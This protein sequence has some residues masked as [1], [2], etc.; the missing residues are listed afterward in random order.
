[1]SICAIWGVPRAGK[2][3]LAV[4]LAY[5]VS[6]GD[7]SICL[8]SPVEYSELSAVLGKKI[9]E[10]HSLRAAL[11]GHAGIRQTVFKVDE[12]LF[13]LAA[14]VTA[15]A[16]DMDY[17]D[18][19]VKR[20]L[21]MTRITFDL[22]IVDCPSEPN[23]LLASWSLN[24]ADKVLLCLGGSPSCVM[25]YK[26]NDKALQAVR[27]KTVYISSEVTPDF[28]YSAMH[29]LLACKPDVRIP[30]MRDAA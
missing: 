27:S 9:P 13:V 28:D 21:E 25:W 2:T 14:P 10:E 6:R 4:N 5:A 8:I 7:K 24:K 30:Y 22:T 20:L 11:R 29:E 26:A 23:N 15:D 12:L 3:T 17:T 16:F 19:Q 18:E 1:M